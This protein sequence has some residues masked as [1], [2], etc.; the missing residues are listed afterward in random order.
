MTLLFP[1]WSSFSATRDEELFRLFLAFESLDHLH[2][3]KS[4]Q[5]I[6]IINKKISGKKVDYIYFLR[7]RW[8][9]RKIERDRGLL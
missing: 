9:A 7:I 8:R 2:L 5:Q 4:S 3:P 1:N 6:L